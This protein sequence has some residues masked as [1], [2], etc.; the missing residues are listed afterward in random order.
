MTDIVERLRGICDWPGFPRFAV[1]IAQDAIAEIERLRSEYDEL[2]I[3]NCEQSDEIKGLR[4][5][6]DRTDAD[7]NTALDAVERLTQEIERLRGENDDLREVATKVERLDEVII[8]DA[9]AEIERLRAFKAMAGKALGE[10]WVEAANRSL[11][12][13]IDEG[14]KK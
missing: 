10:A 11:M 12:R 9:I 7:E 4:W 14:E 2:L 8:D 13:E 3:R 5:D 1:V 6:L